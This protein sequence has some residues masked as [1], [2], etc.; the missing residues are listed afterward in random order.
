MPAAKGSART[1][2]G[3][4]LRGVTRSLLKKSQD[5]QQ[6]LQAPSLAKVSQE[7]ASEWVSVQGSPYTRKV[8]SAL[9]YKQIPFTQHSLMPDNMMGDWEERGFGNIKPKVGKY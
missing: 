1:P 8:Q 6:L 7:W 4:M 5:V 3:P 9:R 2:L